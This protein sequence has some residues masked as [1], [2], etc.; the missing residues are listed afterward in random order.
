MCSC[1]SYWKIGYDRPWRQSTTIGCNTSE[2][3]RSASNYHR[4]ELEVRVLCIQWLSKS[5][6]KEQGS[7]ADIAEE[8]EER[9]PRSLLTRNG[10]QNTARRIGIRLKRRHCATLVSRVVVH[11]LCCIVKRIRS[12][13]RRAESSRCWKHRRIVRANNGLPSNLLISW[14]IVHGVV[15]WFCEDW[16]HNF[17]ELLDVSHERALSCCMPFRMTLS[18]S[19]IP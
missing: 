11:S 17:S 5:S 14:L 12:N 9:F 3:Y 13:G 16:P 19:L 7:Y 15:A 4:F 18:N 1:V 6:Q 8:G 2:M 10:H